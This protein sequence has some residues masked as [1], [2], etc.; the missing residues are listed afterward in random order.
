[1]LAVAQTSAPQIVFTREHFAPTT[2]RFQTVSPP[3]LV[4]S[5]VMPQYH[6][7]S[8][9][10]FTLPFGRA[11]ERDESLEGLSQMREVKTLFLTQSSLPLT[12]LWGGHLRLA[13]FSST[14]HMQNVQLGPS[15]AGGLQDFRPPR[16]NC[17]GGPRSYDLYGVSMSLYFGRD[18]RTRRPTQVWERMTRIVGTALY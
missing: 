11:Y 2:V 16:Q 6:G 13:G 3:L 14:L 4:T 7:K 17:P 5:L 18:S 8:P 15:A 12:Q 10:R 9:T 1:M